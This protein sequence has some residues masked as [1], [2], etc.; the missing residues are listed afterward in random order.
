MLQY[1]EVAVVSASARETA[2]EAASR[3]DRVLGVNAVSHVGGLR[4]PITN[5]KTNKH[6]GPKEI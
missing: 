6:H 3:N 2:F 4:F 1:R 5:E